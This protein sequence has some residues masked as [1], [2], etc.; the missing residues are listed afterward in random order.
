MPNSNR[1]V[2]V[3]IVYQ[4]VQKR[5]QVKARGSIKMEILTSIKYSEPIQM[6]QYNQERKTI[7][8]KAIDVRLSLFFT[9]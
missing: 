5:I 4:T 3:A 7:R 2:A 8:E 1:V 6:E 9:F